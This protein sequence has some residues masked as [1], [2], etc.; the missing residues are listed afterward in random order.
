M[1]NPAVIVADEPVSALDVSIRSQVLNL[2]KRLQAEH[3]LT[4]VVI[5]HDLAVVKYLSDRIGVM[6]LGRMVETGSGDDIYNRAAHPYTAGLLSAMPIPDP[7]IERAKEDGR[8]PGRAAE[9]DQPAVG[10]PVP[11]P[12]PARR[13]AVR[14][15]GADAP[16][17][18]A[19]PPGG[20][21]LPAAAAGRRPGAGRATASV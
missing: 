5:S 14:R 6:Y 9:P 12:L 21:P 4:Y 16:V 3:N 7:T 18:R 19:G 8:G 10:L 17:V 20:L 2:M 1:L 13:A 15:R 11:Y